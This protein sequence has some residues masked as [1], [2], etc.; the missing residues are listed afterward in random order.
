[1]IFQFL[2]DESQSISP[3]RGKAKSHALGADYHDYSLDLDLHGAVDSDK[4]KISATARHIVLVI[5]KE[6]GSEG[7]WPRLTKDKSK[8]P[9]IKVISYS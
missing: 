5:V 7:Y 8:H 2:V 9:Y 3:Y 4:S 6:S 1:M